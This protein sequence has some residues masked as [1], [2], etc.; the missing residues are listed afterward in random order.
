VFDFTTFSY[1]FGQ[2]TTV[3]PSYVDLNSDDGVSVFDFTAFSSN[4]GVG[5]VYQTGFAEVAI[6]PV[7]AS[8]ASDERDA[9][10]QVVEIAAT[11]DTWGIAARERIVDDMS[12]EHASESLDELDL[13]LKA[14]IG[15]LADDIA[16]TW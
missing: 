14:I 9:V 2:D 12:L 15:A 1:W 11:E 7:V 13:D 4:F 10:E 3:A 16:Q 5:I 8:I 6:L